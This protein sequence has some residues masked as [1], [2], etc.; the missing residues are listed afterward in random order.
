LTDDFRIHD[1]AFF[2]SEADHRE[3]SETRA[4][5]EDPQA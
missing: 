3:A 4:G 5:T 2:E 1:L